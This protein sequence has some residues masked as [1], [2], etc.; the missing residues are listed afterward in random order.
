MGENAIFDTESVGGSATSESVM[1]GVRVVD[2]PAAAILAGN[3][4]E[5]RRGEAGPGAT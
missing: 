4:R 3:G 2:G 5:E 1:S